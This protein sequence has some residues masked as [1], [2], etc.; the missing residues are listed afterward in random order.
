MTASLLVSAGA[1]VGSVVSLW[2]VWSRAPEGPARAALATCLVGVLPGLTFV[3]HALVRR[4]FAS[5]NHPFAAYD[6]VTLWPALF[7]ILVGPFVFLRSVVIARP[8][9]VPW[10]VDVLRVL[11]VLG[12]A[13]SSLLAVEAMG[14][15]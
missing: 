10:F 5:A 14:E 13:S 6:L 9:Q 15:V 3:G 2:Y 1:A 12:W 4:H 8:R 11:L 7:W